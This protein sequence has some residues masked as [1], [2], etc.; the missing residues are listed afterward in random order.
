M[1]VT[2]YRDLK[3]MLPSQ[4]AG[5]GVVVVYRTAETA[6]NDTSRQLTFRLRKHTV[7]V[8]H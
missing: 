1:A 3:R 4:T 6:A 7:F 5:N 2:V 8:S